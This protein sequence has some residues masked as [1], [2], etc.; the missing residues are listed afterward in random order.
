MIN[1]RVNSF[2]LVFTSISMTIMVFAGCG[3]LFKKIKKNIT[4]K[5][6]QSSHPEPSA[7]PTTLEPSADY[8]THV[9]ANKTT[10]NVSPAE[11][12]LV[13]KGDTFKLKEGIIYQLDKETGNWIF[14]HKLYDK[15]YYKKNYTVNDG[16]VY[17]NN[18]KTGQ[19]IA[20]KRFF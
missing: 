16:K 17:R 5:P 4:E 9:S 12:T 2:F 15:D 13:V 19:L 7:A 18:P 10:G 14:I 8:S 3:N 1:P 6:E 20:P 11:T